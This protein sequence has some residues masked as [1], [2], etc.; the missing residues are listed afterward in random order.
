MAFKWDVFE[1]DGGDDLT[2]QVFYDDVGQGIVNLF[3]GSNIATGTSGQGTETIVIPASVTNV[4][5][6]VSVN[7]NGNDDFAAIDNFVIYGD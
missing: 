2:Y 7:Q 4:R 5:I 6:T 1:F 3:N